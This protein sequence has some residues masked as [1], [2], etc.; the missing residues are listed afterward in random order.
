LPGFTVERNFAPMDFL[1]HD[2]ASLIIL[3]AN[4]IDLNWD[5]LVT[6]RLEGIASRGNRV[7]YALKP[8][9]LLDAVKENNL[10]NPPQK[11]DRKGGKKDGTQKKG[12]DEP[13]PLLAKWKVK[14][15]FDL[16]KLMDHP[17]SFAS[18]GWSVRDKIGDRAM[19]IERPFGKGSIVLMAE[20]SDF[21]NETTVHMGRLE[22]VTGAIG[23][24]RRVIFDEEHLGI[25]ESGSVAGM[26]RQF[27]LTGLAIGLALV[28]GLFIWKNASGFPPPAPLRAGERYA[29]RTSQ[30]G[31]LTLLKRHIPSSQVAAVCWR[32]WLSVNRREVSPDRLKKAEEIASRST[33]MPLEATRQI[34]AVLQAK[35]E[36]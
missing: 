35:G 26:A 2:G 4:P 5:P 19:A 1:N 10:T 23:P 6:R 17:L 28:A 15:V 25:A 34:Q 9:T 14:L 32:E 31:L 13:P 16:K 7:I 24:F 21:T 18:E 29:G 22:Q 12:P 27:R 20:S 8:D 3:A 30:A 33:A 36:L 11:R